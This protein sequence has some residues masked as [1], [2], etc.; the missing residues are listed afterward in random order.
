MSIR[1]ILVPPSFGS[2]RSGQFTYNFFPSLDVTSG[3]LFSAGQP[4][5]TRLVEQARALI[6]KINDKRVAETVTELIA[7]IERTASALKVAGRDISPLPPIRAS[8]LDDGSVILEWATQEFRLGFNIEH[9]P[10][11]SGFFLATSKRLGEKGMYSRLAGI[12]EESLV[13]LVVQFVLD[14]S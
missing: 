12:S 2:G 8:I 3:T 11:E 10:S 13:P 9:D 14:N 1:D 5:G 4:L 6:T 7:T